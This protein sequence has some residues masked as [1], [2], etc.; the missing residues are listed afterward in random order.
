[1][2]GA[3]AAS[4]AGG[5]RRFSERGGL[6]ADWMAQHRAAAVVARPDR[7]VYGIA[8]DANEL[9]RMIEGLGRAIFG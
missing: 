4:D 7:Y 2:I 8:H 9:N 5:I 1:M 6:F 3:G